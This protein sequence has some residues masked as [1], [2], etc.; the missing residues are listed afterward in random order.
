MVGLLYEEGESDDQVDKIW[1][2]IPDEVG[3][4]NEVE[5]LK[6]D[7]LAMLPEDRDYYRFNGSLTTPPATEGVRWLVLK[8]T[9]EVSK[10]QIE[11]FE[12]IIG[13]P[14]NRP[15]AANQRTTYS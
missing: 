6:F 5:G 11:A 4:A 3:V 10:E 14:N 1:A 15:V 2:A 13:F 8:E 9:G 12:D 7:P